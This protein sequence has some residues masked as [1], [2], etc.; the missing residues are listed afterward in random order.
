M[1]S[2]IAFDLHHCWLIWLGFKTPAPLLGTLAALVDRA[3]LPWRCLRAG[4][5]APRSIAMILGDDVLR[6][7]T[8][9]TELKNKLLDNQLVAAGDGQGLGKK[10]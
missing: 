3:N 6:C 2:L 8:S 10:F 4:E 5:D 1:G 7:T 9:A